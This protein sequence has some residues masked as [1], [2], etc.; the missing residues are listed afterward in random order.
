[1][2]TPRVGV[3]A[4]ALDGKVYV[5][6]GLSW[7]TR[8]WG[9]S[10]HSIRRPTAGAR[11]PTCRLRGSSLRPRPWTDKFMRSAALQRIS[12]H[13][14]GRSVHAIARSAP[15]CL[16]DLLLARC[17]RVLPARLA[18]HSARLCRYRQFVSSQIS[19]QL[20]GYAR[21]RRARLD[22][23]LDLFIRSR[24]RSTTYAST[25]NRSQRPGRPLT[26]A[27]PAPGNSDQHQPQNPP[28]LATQEPHPA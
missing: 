13:Y 20:G 21:N 3:W 19:V 8:R 17:G 6:G 27:P 4:A 15:G 9:R 25:A 7:R 24:A 5:I 26:R 23:G 14:R 28:E 1:M 11:W 18:C 16:H 10:K 12:R 2:P 22:Q